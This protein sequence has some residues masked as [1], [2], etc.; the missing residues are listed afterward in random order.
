MKRKLFA[1]CILLW[2][3][4]ALVLTYLYFFVYYT[5]TIYVNS[6]VWGYEVEF[7]S[8]STAQKRRESCPEEECIITDVSPF[9]YNITISKEGYENKLMSIDVAPRRKETLFIELTK[10]VV[11]EPLPSLQVIE[12]PKE[13]IE[14][15]RE[16]NRYYLSFQ[17][18]DGRK[19]RF[20]ESAEENLEM[21][22]QSPDNIQSIQEF[23]KLSTESIL[24]DE[25]SWSPDIFLSIW[26]ESYI[27]D[28]QAWRLIELDFKIDIFYIKSWA[29]EGEYI[30]ITEKWAFLYD[31][32]SR[33]PEFQYL[34]R[35][36]LYHKD[37]LIWVVYGDEEQKKKNLSLTEDGNLIIKYSPSDKTKKILY[38]T[39]ENIE[40]LEW[41]E[42][43]IIITIDDQEYELSNY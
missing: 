35:D 10:K 13:K 26:E 6:N 42:N 24:A 2:T 22:Y 14:R 29:S 11:L 15:I 19:L 23:P 33:N 20:K 4:W 40:R 38:R 8:K 12:T 17:L 36:Y 28:T 27:F 43:Q 3:I 25:I 7:F 37:S 1:L 30:I 39:S 32:R 31:T 18:Q 34:F 9:E 41:K 16:E 5:A 21:I